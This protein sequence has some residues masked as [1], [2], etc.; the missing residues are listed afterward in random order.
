M[1]NSINDMNTRQILVL[2]A[3][4]VLSGHARAQEIDKELQTLADKP[5]ISIKEHGGKKVTV[6]DFTD[7]QGGT[8]GEL[9]KYI[10]EQ[11]ELLVG[12]SFNG[13]YGTC[14]VQNV[15]VKI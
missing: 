1:L 15:T 13:N 2:L 12:K 8:E 11:L 14:T 4:F 9:G 3:C 5:A 7:L 6:I 10:A